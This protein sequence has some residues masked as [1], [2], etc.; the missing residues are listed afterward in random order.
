MAQCQGITK[1]GE[2]CKREAGEGSA[3]CSIHVDQEVRPRSA[4]ATQTTTEWDRD[5]LVK[6]AIGFGLIGA[7]LLFRLRR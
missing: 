7:I 6:T 4:P 1:K 3:Y 2:R 5:A